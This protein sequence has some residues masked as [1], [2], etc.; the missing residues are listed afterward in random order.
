MLS[1]ILFITVSVLLNALLISLNG[2][3]IT[4]PD[5][6]SFGRQ[7]SSTETVLLSHKDL[8]VSQTS[9]GRGR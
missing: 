4:A 9:R 6:A 3:Q 7:T 5:S 8:S 1:V 2:G